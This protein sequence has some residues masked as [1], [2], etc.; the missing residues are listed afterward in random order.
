MYVSSY[1]ILKCLASNSCMIW[2]PKDG[3]LVKLRSSSLEGAK[4]CKALMR[5]SISWSLWSTSP[6]LAECTSKDHGGEQVGA[7]PSS[8]QE[9]GEH[10]FACLGFSS[11]TGRIG[12][13]CATSCRSGNHRGSKHI[14]PR[15]LGVCNGTAWS[16]SRWG[17]VVGAMDIARCH[18]TWIV[19]G[20]SWTCWVSRSRGQVHFLVGWYQLEPLKSNFWWVDY[21]IE[22]G[23]AKASSWHTFLWHVVFTQSFLWTASE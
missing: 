7:D 5:L 14:A 9:E 18:I 8:D 15:D 16:A 23:G 13:S 6:S 2:A 22:S 12:S 10:P 20:S 4:P 11:A 3:S 19:V 1:D 21:P 17:A